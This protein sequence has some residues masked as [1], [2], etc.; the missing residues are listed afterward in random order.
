[1]NKNFELPERVNF[2][3]TSKCNQSCIHCFASSGHE[4]K[5]MSTKEVKDFIDRLEGTSVK[6]LSFS[7][8]EPLI[9][10]DIFDLIDHVKKRELYIGLS[11]N[12]TLIDEITAVKIAELGVDSVAVSIHG[13]KESTH[14]IIVR[15]KGAYL[16]AI[17]G[18]KN[19]LAE[20]VPTRVLT[21]VMRQ[22]YSEI[23][24][25]RKCME[26]HGINVNKILHFS[27]MPLRPAGRANVNWNELVLS[28]DELWHLWEERWGSIGK[29]VFGDC[30]LPIPIIE[31][32]DVFLKE[33]P[34]D[35]T[36]EKLKKICEGCVAGK[37]FCEITSNGNVLLCPFVRLPIGNIRKNTLENIWKTS[38]LI[39]KVQNREFTGKCGNCQNADICGGCRAEAFVRSGDILGSDP[40]CKFIPSTD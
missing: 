5:D 24:Y 26:K 19:L 23:P 27:A 22:N 36:A 11:T 34:Y 25:I 28:P 30:P 31:T 40:T 17:E 38:Y 6:Y 37:I 32:L 7:G 13:S 8:G 18:I 20:N 21:T 12:G 33:K 9:R 35:L 3:I 2:E 15:K 10:S 4:K 29:D 16:K 14:D 39:K 1:M